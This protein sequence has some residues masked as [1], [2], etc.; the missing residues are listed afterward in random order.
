MIITWEHIAAD[1]KPF[2][3]DNR[4]FILDC[5]V[6][7]AGTSAYRKALDE[8]GLQGSTGRRSNPHDNAKAESFMKT[9]KREHHYL[10]EY[11]TFADV[12]ECVPEF[13]DQMKEN[14]R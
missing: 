9:L 11:R 1:T 8:F 2:P 3:F 4:G 10:N 14:S 13:I 7:K 6:L 5:E 12:V